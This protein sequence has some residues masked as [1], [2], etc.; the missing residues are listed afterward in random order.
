MKKLIGKL[1]PK[2]YGIYFNLL[3]LFSKKKAVLKVF[4]VFCTV[5]KGK[6]KPSQK[7]FIDPAKDKIHTVCEHQIQAYHWKGTKETVLLIH[8]WESNTHRWHKLIEKLQ[9][10]DYNIIA[11]DAPAHGY[12][13]GDFLYVPLYADIL[14]HMIQYYK[15]QHLVGHS[16]GGMTVMYHQ[17]YHPDSNIKKIVTIGSPAEFHEIMTNYQQMLGFSDRL[18]NLLDDYILKRFGFRIHEL[19]TPSYAKSNTKKGLLFHDRLD[20]IAAY[21]SSERVHAAWKWSQLIS[22]EGLWHSMHQDE[23]NEQLITFLKTS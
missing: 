2:L 16:L 15:P 8:G 23:V 22:T 5:R 9:K 18:R 14:E 10:A 17:Y 7:N 6:I 3:L 12:S 21:H 11:F 4:N 1:V 13:S 20:K 19:S